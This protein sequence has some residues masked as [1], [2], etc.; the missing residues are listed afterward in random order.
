MFATLRAR[1]QDTP[2]LTLEVTEGFYTITGWKYYAGGNS[3]A[4]LVPD[5]SLYSSNVRY[6]LLYLGVDDA[7]HI[8]TG[9]EV[10]SDPVKPTPPIMS[11]PLA[12]VYMFAGQTAITGSE[13]EEPRLFLG[14]V[15]DSEQ[16]AKRTG[17]FVLTNA[18]SDLPQGVALSAMDLSW[19]KPVAR[20]I[21]ADAYLTIADT[22]ALYVP[23]YYEIA[24]TLELQGDA[25]LEIG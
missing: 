2:D 3:P 15:P 11:M 9:A 24:G 7:L 25:A 8:A 4:F 14:S 20:V 5:G 18:D 12:Y 13:I 17:H 22:Y 21:P 10:T 19:A 23:V 1:P 6:D 16:K